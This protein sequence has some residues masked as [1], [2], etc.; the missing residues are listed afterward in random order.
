MERARNLFAS[1]SVFLPKTVVLETEWVL[2]RLYRLGQAAVADALDRLISL[3]NVHCEDEAA[4]RQALGWNRS[5]LDFADALHLA[6]NGRAQRFAT[7]DRPLIKTA[8]TI[9]ISVFEP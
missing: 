1:G 5:G 8:T 3:P 9:G 4:V 6:S 7:F 2:R